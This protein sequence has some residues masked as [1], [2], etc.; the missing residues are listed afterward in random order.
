MASPVETVRQRTLRVGARLEREAVAAPSLAPPP[1]V[2]SISVSIDA[3]HVRS[4]RGYQGRS[5]EVFAAQIGNDD[6]RHV[7]FSSVP[8]DADRQR[9]QLRGVLQGFGATAGTAVTV[10]SNRAEGPRS[11]GEAASIGPVHHVLDWFH[12]SM[13]I[14][15]AAQSITGWP[16]ATNGDCENGIRHGTLDRL[17][18][19]RPG[20]D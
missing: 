12:L 18:G 2:R 14:Q 4:A 9:W 5:F 16:D 10:L 1:A 11:L 7:V 13:R 8:A 19:G 15:H 17:S 6:G 20:C 3:G